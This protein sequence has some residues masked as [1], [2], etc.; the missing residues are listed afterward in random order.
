MRFYSDN[1][2]TAC[3][4]ILEALTRVNTGRVKAYGD[5]EWTRELDG[6][7]SDYFGR[8]VRAFPVVTGTAAN[9]LSLATLSPPYGA[10]FAHQQAHVVSDEC[11]AT[12]F[13]SNGARLVLVPG[14]NGRMTPETLQAALEAIPVS[15][16]T[17]QPAALTLTQATELGT[18]YRLDDLA[19]LTDIARRHGLK[20]HMDGARFA[21][22]LE[23]LGCSPA[24][25]T[26]RA[27][28][29]VLS[30]GATK[31]GALAAEAVIFFDPQLVRDFELR[32][33]R[34]GHLISKSRF[35]SAQL[36]AYLQSGVWKRN[37][38]RTNAL[39]RKIGAAAGSALLYPVEANEIFLQ[40]EDAGKR[41]LRA[42]GF[43]FYD[44]GAER[45]GCARFVVSWDQPEADVEALCRALQSLSRT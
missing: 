11:G 40:L 32:R 13:F 7:F 44:W 9:S 30:F 6:V 34:A 21:N 19:A 43:E 38:A 36:L 1:T 29:D 15:V 3:P 41:T 17:V 14:E 28:V 2:A 37:A 26:W 27:G 23:F 12:E 35:V 22:A 24:D 4:E 18:S 25:M 8:E 31:N 42:A 5:D 45:S 16:H 39:A 10:V 20:V 33:K